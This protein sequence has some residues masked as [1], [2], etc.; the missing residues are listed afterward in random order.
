M[1]T[2]LRALAPVFLCAMA[3]AQNQ[4][5][6][7][8]ILGA[9]FLYGRGCAICHTSRAAS[10]ATANTPL[11][12]ADL[13]PLYGQVFRFGDAGAYA[14]TMPANASAGDLSQGIFLC[15]SCH[16][17]NLATSGM[18]K[19]LTVESLPD[20]GHAPT[21]LG[22]DGS[23]PGNYNN[24]HPVGP[25]AVVTCGAKGWDCAGGG[26]APIAMTGAASSAFVRNYGF[27]VG[28]YF[29]KFG[30]S[31]TAVSCVTCHDPHSNFIYSGTM[32]GVKGNYPTRFFLRGYYQPSTGGNNTSQFCRQCHA[33]ESNEM[34][35]QLNVPTS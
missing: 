27:P 22:N 4:A 31:V 29:G 16:D 21:L 1:R 10:P 26:S 17:G 6:S 14:V 28:G 35:G 3:N 30:N 32:F 7:D 9:H 11:W 2:L 8:N 25:S 24:D 20:G 13:T 5:I 34:A 15:L 19:G 18:M 12:G 23:T 33:R